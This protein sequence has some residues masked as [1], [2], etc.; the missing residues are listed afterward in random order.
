MEQNKA[1]DKEKQLRQIAEM[2]LLN[3]TLVECAGLIHGKTGL[4]IFFFHYA[5]YTGNALFEDY[6]MDLISEEQHQIHT[7]S[8]AN[9]EN[10][11]AGIGVG[12]DYLIRNNFIDADADI[13]DDFDQRMFRAV[14]YD[15]WPDFSLYDGLMG[16]GRYWITR[17][18][19]P[20]P[21]AQAR[22]C[23]LRIITLIEENLPKIPANEQIDVYC[24]LHDLQ[25]ISDFEVWGKHTLPL[26]NRISNSTI[27]N[28]DITNVIER[29]FSC[30]GDSLTG[31]MARLVQQ[32]RYFNADRQVDINA[33]LMQIPDLDMEKAPESMGLLNGYAGE[34]M[35]RLTAINQIDMIWTNLL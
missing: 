17:L 23:L 2:L 7:N 9:Y 1:I 27:Q 34:G 14:M 29:G 8:P 28:D 4:A 26:R 3:G 24:F 16:Y 21:S 18:R 35:L 5:R 6:A 25:E 15:P 11:I 31:N 32:C 20:V 13:F 30:L 22:E 19:Y 10:G 12:I 33:T